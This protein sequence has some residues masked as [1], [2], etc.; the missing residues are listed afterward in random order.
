MD[1][2][3]TPEINS[4]AI[5]YAAGEDWKSDNAAT[6]QYD[7]YKVHPVLN[8]IDGYNYS[9][10][11]R[12]GVPAIF[13]MNFQTVSTAQKLPT[14]HGLTGDYL[15][16]GTTPGPLLVRALNYINT[17]VGLMVNEIRAH[18][19]AG[20]TAI[21]ISAKHGQSPTDPNDLVRFP[22]APIV[23]AVNAGGAVVHPG[24][25]DL[26]I[27]ETDDDGILWWLSDRSQAA[28]DFGKNYLLTH[29]A[30]GNNISD[31]PVTVQASGLSTVYAGAQSARYF[32]ERNSDP[33]H[34][35]IFAIVQHGVVYT[36]G[37]GKIAEHG[38]AGQQDRNV[39]I[40]I[41]GPGVEAGQ[42]VSDWVETTQIAPTILGLLRLNPNEL[43]RS[44]S[45]TLGCCQGSSLSL[46]DLERVGA[47]PRRAV[48]TARQWRPARAVP[49][50][51]RS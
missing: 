26:V 39:P 45:S 36:G 47:E 38:G 44:G 40:L 6:M 29:D 17:E 9:R 32:G 43:K 34:P 28:A 5:G 12:V 10:T 15:P 31:N 3:F 23:S 19:I 42:I 16:G 50:R 18:G 37:I 8:E 14:S 11:D 7:S 2:Y 25:G 33:R 27:L 21:I 41:D 22:D 49:A 20:S 46:P 48:F 30:T 35:D 1:D 51:R 13:G 24:T 4:Q